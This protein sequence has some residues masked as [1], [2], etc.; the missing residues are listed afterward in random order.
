MP[1]ARRWPLILA[2]TL[3]CCGRTE[4][5]GSFGGAAAATPSTPQVG[6]G[7]VPDEA[8][9]STEPLLI[10]FDLGLLTAHTLDG[11]VAFV[12][13]V[14]SN[15]RGRQFEWLIG[16]PGLVARSHLPQGSS[17]RA[18][19][20]VRRDGLTEF[21]SGPELDF[22][23]GWL[24]S[25]GVV[26][27]SSNSGFLVDRGSARR[28]PFQPVAALAPSGQVAA[29]DDARRVVWVDPKLG[30]VV[31]TTAV[32][33]ALETRQV[34]GELYATT[35]GTVTASTP[36]SDLVL[37]A[38]FAYPQLLAANRL[39]QALVSDAN[40][41]RL[42]LVDFARQTIAEVRL[43]DT[44]LSALGTFVD[45]AIELDDQGTIYATFYGEGALRVMR[46]GDLGARWAPA[47]TVPLTTRP[48]VVRVARTAR[49]LVIAGGRARGETI[50]E[51][52]FAAWSGDDGTQTELPVAGVATLD[53]NV[54]VTLSSDGKH[55]AFWAPEP[56]GARL[57]ALDVATA[58]TT[59]I[60]RRALTLR[61]GL[62]V[63]PRLAWLE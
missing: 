22:V 45:R 7:D 13:R 42:A 37:A 63:Y 32:E 3:L 35:A 2:L 33:R 34:E 24:S 16:G 12:Q 31:R 47:G 54:P 30:A 19:A 51:W 57:Y 52:S 14:T 17:T 49:G 48:D 39:R 56:G 9:R 61:G 23:E 26:G 44:Q 20:L 21:E 6:S 25:S 11:R 38:P 40:R 55:G 4:P 53:A 10:D 60:E 27:Q 59:L 8:S 46:T 41:S 62:A 18:L 36:S 29:F 50:T 15:S 28:F 43:E 58:T 1:T 5:L